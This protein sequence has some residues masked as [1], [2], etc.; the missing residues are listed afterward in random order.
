MIISSFFFQNPTIDLMFSYNLFFLF[1][2]DINYEKLQKG[3]IIDLLN[4]QQFLLK[5]LLNNFCGV[6]KT[7]KPFEFN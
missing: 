7:I 5:L 2:S 6:L 1:K 4:F 3:R